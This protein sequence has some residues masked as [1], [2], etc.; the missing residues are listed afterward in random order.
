MLLFLGILGYLVCSFVG[1]NSY[2]HTFQIKFSFIA[3]KKKI[4]RNHRL[5]ALY[6]FFTGP[7]GLISWWICLLFD[8][9]MRGYSGCKR[10][11]I[12]QSLDLKELTARKKQCGKLD[13]EEEELIIWCLEGKENKNELA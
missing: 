6:A 11:W 5:S 13:E 12:W 9:D 2:Y 3:N 10:V 7:I 1:M 4:R 8:S